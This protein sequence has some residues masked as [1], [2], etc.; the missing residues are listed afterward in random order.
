MV[1]SLG[2]LISFKIFVLAIIIIP[3]I[4]ILSVISTED[5]RSI[6]DTLEID[7]YEDAE[8]VSMADIGVKIISIAVRDHQ[9]FLVRNGK[10]IKDDMIKY[11]FSICL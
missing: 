11:S 8:R 4:Q 10:I 3:A 2:F 9:Y 5:I 6:P 1:N 7:M